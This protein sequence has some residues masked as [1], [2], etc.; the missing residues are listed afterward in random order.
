[1]SCGNWKNRQLLASLP[2]GT[3]LAPRYHCRT[4]W[5]LTKI[6]FDLHDT[7]CKC[8]GNLK[9]LVS[10]VH[11][12][13]LALL[14]NSFYP[15]HDS[16][17][18]WKAQEVRDCDCEMM[19]FA[20]LER[21][22]SIDRRPCLKD[23]QFHPRSRNRTCGSLNTPWVAWKHGPVNPRTW[24]VVSLLVASLSLLSEVIVGGQFACLIEDVNVAGASS[25]PF[26]TPMQS[27]CSVSVA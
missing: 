16:L 15:F 24:S 4:R 19:R 18:R 7:N 17:D 13:A 26:S 12:E 11:L 25:D 20:M 3:C 23:R 22:K 2:S 10:D 6:Y 14:L 8:R 5:T 27:I 9:F 21:R 1:L